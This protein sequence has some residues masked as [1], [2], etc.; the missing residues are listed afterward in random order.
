MSDRV[1]FDPDAWDGEYQELTGIRDELVIDPELCE[2]TFCSKQEAFAA[3]LL[4]GESL[5]GDER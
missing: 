4:I 5:L 1:P 3:G 2:R